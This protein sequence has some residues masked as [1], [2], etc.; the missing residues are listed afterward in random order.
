MERINHLELY[1]ICCFNFYFWLVS[2]IINCDFNLIGYI[3]YR[4]ASW[5]YY[6]EI[7]IDEKNG[8]II[9]LKK[10]LD[11]T[12]KVDLITDKFD[13]KRF[14]FL[15]LTRSG[16]TKFL[17]SYRTHKNHELLILKNKT[18]KELVEKYIAEKISIY[19][20]N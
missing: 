18:D 13:P 20:N 7:L 19:N 2:W 11:R 10:I 9:Q 3:L 8:K 16:K 6:S 12:Q 1:F 17:M 4:F 14:E 5:I 15:E